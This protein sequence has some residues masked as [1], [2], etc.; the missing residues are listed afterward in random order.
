MLQ[1]L[2]SDGISREIIISVRHEAN[3][4]AKGNNKSTVSIIFGHSQKGKFQSSMKAQHL[5]Y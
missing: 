3:E 2:I 1:A 4:F 5:S